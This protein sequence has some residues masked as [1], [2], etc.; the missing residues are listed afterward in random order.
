MRWQDSD[1]TRGAYYNWHRRIR[2]ARRNVSQGGT[3]CGVFVWGDEFG[4]A[5]LDPGGKI[6]VNF[7]RG[8]LRAVKGANIGRIAAECIRAAE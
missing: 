1:T 8:I 2:K 3:P 5:E 7:G 6:R 4:I